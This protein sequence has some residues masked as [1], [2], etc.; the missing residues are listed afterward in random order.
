M[1]KESYCSAVSQIRWTAEQRRKIEALLSLPADSPEFEEETEYTV[2]GEV[3]QEELRA[4]NERNAKPEQPEKPRRFKLWII[5]S[6]AALLA[7]GGGAAAAVAMRQKD[8]TIQ[9]NS[10]ED[11]LDTGL[12]LHLTDQYYNQAEHI[13]TYRDP[14]ATGWGEL[15]TLPCVVSEYGWY[16]HNTERYNIDEVT[17]GDDTY[18]VYDEKSYL[19]FT[20]R[21]SG[22]TVPLC[23]RPNCEHDGSLYCTASTKAYN[24]SLP[25]SYDGRLIAS[26]IKNTDPDNYENN[27]T[28]V[29]LIEY[30]PDGTA[31]HELCTISDKESYFVSEPYI[32][33]GYAWMIVNVI[34][35]KEDDPLTHRFTEN[36]GWEIRGYELATGNVVCVYSVMAKPDEGFY[37]YNPAKLVPDGDYL[38]F[39]NTEK[40]LYGSGGNSR[41]PDLPVGLH[42]LNLYSGQTEH[43]FDGFIDEPAKEVNSSY[44]V[45]GNYVIGIQ[46]SGI[47]KVY[48]MET[49]EDI[50]LE[51]C[52]RA[53]MTDGEYI[54]MSRYDWQNK[55]SEM[56]IYDFSGKLIQNIPTDNVFSFAQDILIAN[57][58]MYILQ[59]GEI[60]T[61]KMKNGDTW[62]THS[63]PQVLYSDLESVKAGNPDWKLAYEFRSLEE[64]NPVPDELKS[65]SAENTT[66][67]AKEEEN[68]EGSDDSDAQ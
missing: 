47:L 64:N 41:R 40:S 66:D 53:Y 17:D 2:I 4:L 21:E 18:T 14:R 58:S 45:S 34:N 50:M 39:F 1:N 9:K 63:V 49:K 44:T 29:V 60:T 51:N 54:Y 67:N 12:N 68:T 7:A 33:R 61:E 52:T 5:L 55:I 38:Y 42:R 6:A 16:H 59:N 20:D 32:H 35:S 28:S 26:A 27:K 37:Y 10:I 24:A 65:D 15:S 19:A 46:G 22:Q 13:M 23:A 11:E 48:N 43:V 57:G 31:I 8:T 36:G 30:E 56:N 3:P 25:V 62:I